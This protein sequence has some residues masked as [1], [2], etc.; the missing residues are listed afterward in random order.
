M[1]RQIL[2]CTMFVAVT[3]ALGAQEASQTGSYQ[4]T[5]NPPPDDQITTSSTQAAKPPAGQLVYIQPVAP[6][7]VKVEP[8]PSPVDPSV[9]YPEPGRANQPVLTERNYP[10][11]P[12]SDIVHPHPLRRGEI[13]EGTIIRVR[14]LERLSTVQSEKGEAFRTRVASDVLAGGEVRIPAGA[15]IDGRLVQVSSGHAGGHGSMR[16]QPE[17]VI[18]P[19]GTRYRLRA[20]LTGTPGSRTH[21]GSEGT[22]LPNSRI[23]RDSIEYGGAVG[24]GA[25]T[26][27]FMGG[28]VGALAGSLIGAG[29]ITVHLLVSHP[30]ATLES[31]TALLLTLTEPLYMVPARDREN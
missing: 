23:K 8:Q 5:S 3:A 28:P 4:G 31:G 7:Q 13:E 12:D 26:G 18:L 22:V 30:Q 1:N 10:Y 17:V 11:D 2:V 24:A 14:L 9:N 29:V 19:D 16:L 15:E 25:V 6:A 20:E 27:A 21:V